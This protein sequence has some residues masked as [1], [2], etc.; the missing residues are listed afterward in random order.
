[1]LNLYQLNRFVKPVELPVIELKKTELDLLTIFNQHGFEP[2]ELSPIAVLGACSTVAP[3]DQKKILTALRGTEVLA[4]ATNS[5]ALH[6]SDLKKRKVLTPLP[7]EK[8][9]FSAIQR[10][11]RTQAITGKGFTPHFKIGCLV[12]SG[13]DTGSFSF[14]KEALSEHLHIMNALYADYYKVDELS[15]K[16]LCRKGYPDSFDLAKQIQEYVVRQHPDIKINIV[17]TPEKEIGYYKGV[18]YKVDIKVNGKNYEIA[19]GGF[20]D[21]TQQLLQNK[22]ERFLITGFGFEFMYRIMKGMV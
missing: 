22:K 7:N 15:F 14:E 11:V 18:Q 21:W 17:E 8:I 10:H 20:V 9:R 16:F 13:L 2:I 1:M 4:D 5:I 19:D 6:I 12:T 3:A